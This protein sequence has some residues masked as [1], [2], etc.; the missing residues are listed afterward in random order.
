MNRRLVLFACFLTVF[1]S[2]STRYGYGIIL[3]EMLP[4]LGITKTQAGVIYTSFFIAYTLASPVLGLL[5][6]RSNTRFLL[7]SFVALLGA[8]ACLMAASSSIPASSLFFAMA[9]IGSAACWAPVMALARRLASD[10]SLTSLQGVDRLQYSLY[11]LQDVREQHRYQN[12]CG[13]DQLPPQG[14]QDRTE[15]QLISMLGEHPAQQG[16]A[17][18]ADYVEHQ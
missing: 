12:Q 2:Y 14:A 1:V 7:S 15:R 11:P 10:R 4:A 5:A 17:L 13:G 3:P 16:L 9:G 8:G 6:D 18:Q